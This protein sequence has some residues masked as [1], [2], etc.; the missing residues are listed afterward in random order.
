[1]TRNPLVLVSFVVTSTHLLNHLAVQHL[2]NC[3]LSVNKKVILPKCAQEMSK[4]AP[5]LM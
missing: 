4:G 2:E 1:M 3:V 5:K